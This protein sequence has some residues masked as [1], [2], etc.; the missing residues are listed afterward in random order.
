MD[1]AGAYGIQGAGGR[2][3]EGFRGSLTNVIGLP[4]EL[5]EELLG[6]FG[7]GL[8]DFSGRAA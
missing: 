4:V 3:V 7:F 6:R 1:K 2:L 8:G 5:L